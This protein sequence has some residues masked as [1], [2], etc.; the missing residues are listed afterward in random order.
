MQRFLPVHAF[1][2]AAVLLATGATNAQ[3]SATSTI[4]LR[5]SLADLDPTDGI[6]PTLTFD[7]DSR[8]TASWGTE[9]AGGSTSSPQQGASAFGTVATSGLLDGSG[10]SASFTGDPLASAARISASA[11]A[12]SLSV[13]GTG[14]AYVTTPSSGQPWFVLSPHTQVTMAGATTIA[15]DA[16]ASGSAF[17]EIDVALHVAGSSD[18]LSMD[19]ATAGYYAPG[20]G[21]LAGSS[22]DGVTVTFT[23]DSDTPEAVGYYIGVFAS[24]S[25]FE[26]GLPPV[27]EPSGAA[28]LLAGASALLGRTLGV[29][30]LKRRRDLAACS[31]PARRASSPSGHT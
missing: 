24:A 23:N 29:R 21:D 20:T 22:A 12:D 27:D 3:T 10:G 7:P 2:A 9:S 30:A 11:V 1:L 16:S 8:S 31:E 26:S 4:D 17:G 6:L 19:Y 15:W 13:N 25:D 5:F 14:A 18:A 28:L